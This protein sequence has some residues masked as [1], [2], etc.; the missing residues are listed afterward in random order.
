M[1]CI[2]IKVWVEWTAVESNCGVQNGLHWYQTVGFRMDCSGIKLWGSEWTALVSNCGVQNGLHWYQ[3]VGFRMDCT[4]I[5]V[6]VE[7]TALISK[8]G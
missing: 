3:T 1:D 6:W 5:K 8:Y 2:G 7:W 4:D